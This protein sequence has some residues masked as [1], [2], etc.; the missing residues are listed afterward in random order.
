MS[1]PKT[2]QDGNNGNP[3]KN[4][5]PSA[6]ISN[7]KKWNSKNKQK[8]QNSGNGNSNNGKKF[9][10]SKT[11]GSM[12]GK[13]LSDNTKLI[14]EWKEYHEAMVLQATVDNRQPVWGDAIKE[15]KRPDL[16]KSFKRKTMDPV[17]DGW[18][19][20]VES[21]V[22]DEHGQPRK[23]TK[24]EPIINKIVQINDPQLKDEFELEYNSHNKFVD[25]KKNS[26]I[27]YEKIFIVMNQGQIAPAVKSRLQLS[28]AYK[29]AIKKNDVIDILCA[30]RDTCYNAS[31]IGGEPTFETFKNLRVLLNFKQ[32]PNGEI[33]PFSDKLT[34]RYN[35]T[36]KRQG[37]CPFGKNLMIN[38][39]DKKFPH[40]T[41]HDYDGVGHEIISPFPNST[42]HNVKISVT[43]MTKE[44]KE[45]CDE[46]YNDIALARLLILNNNR[47]HVRTILHN[48][49]ISSNAGY[50][51]TSASTLL[52]ITSIKQDNNNQKIDQN[53][54]AH[55]N[56]HAV[57]H[58]GNEDNKEIPTNNGQSEEQLEER[59]DETSESEPTMEDII[60]AATASSNDGVEDIDPKDLDFMEEEPER[61]ELVCGMVAEHKE[62]IEYDYYISEGESYDYSSDEDSIP[63]LISKYSEHSSSDEDSIP[64]LINREF[65]NSSS[66]EEESVMSEH[67]EQYQHNPQ[68]IRTNA[69]TRDTVIRTGTF[70]MNRRTLTVATDAGF[71]TNNTVGNPN[72]AYHEPVRSYRYF[73]NYFGLSDA[74]RSFLYQEIPRGF[75]QY[76]ER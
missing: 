36:V 76:G 55:V 3:P 18:G 75:F 10:G 42:G 64:D 4:D 61:A 39:I 1:T 65:G 8:K 16:G 12:K 57:E 38:V 56:V 49:Y 59:D 41:I 21:P 33:G 40:Y 68:P 32:K 28:D 54:E 29:A 72:E 31:S 53:G 7:K 9:D 27:E 2:Q 66:D 71:G 52:Q 67:S 62:S 17:N 43:K 13:T 60:A 74:P 44:E 24:G 34:S 63:D 23:T 19:E 5:G 47:E 30:I 35:N 46:I 20:I 15:L 69:N 26:H 14:D 11:S 45:E 58:T 22:L 37:D 6:G 73:R 70:N 50:P 25:E 48:L 51:N